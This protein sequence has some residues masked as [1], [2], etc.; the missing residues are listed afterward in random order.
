[1]INSILALFQIALELLVG[2]TETQ[3]YNFN[4]FSAEPFLWNWLAG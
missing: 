3:K 1:M 4:P 2:H